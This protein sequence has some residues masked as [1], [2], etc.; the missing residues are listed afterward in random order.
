MPTSEKRLLS[1]LWSNHIFVFVFVVKKVA[2]KSWVLLAFL[3]VR[4]YRLNRLLKWAV[5][6]LLQTKT[7]VK[8][9]HPAQL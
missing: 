9:T 1:K 3:G 6:F 4:C 2:E 7:S 8:E 5:E